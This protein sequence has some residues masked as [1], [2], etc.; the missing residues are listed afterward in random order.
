MLTF[1]PPQS[2]LKKKKKNYVKAKIFLFFP[3]LKNDPER[4][5][6]YAFLL[7]NHK[8]RT[9]IHH[10]IST[11]PYCSLIFTVTGLDNVCAKTMNSC[12]QGMNLFKVKNKNLNLKKQPRL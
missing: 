11:R 6:C 9:I 8:E 12:H 3:T 7:G 2:L 4:K 10:T 5:K 1:F